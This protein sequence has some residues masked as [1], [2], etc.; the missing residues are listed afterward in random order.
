M[1]AILWRPLALFEGSTAR[2]GMGRGLGDYKG[3]P[4][5]WPAPQYDE[6]E[7]PEVAREV[8]LPELVAAEIALAGPTPFVGERYLN[9]TAPLA[10]FV[11]TIP[12]GVLATME[13]Q[14]FPPLESDE[15]AMALALLLVAEDF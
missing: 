3:T 2:Y 15:G 13:M 5:N 6:I 1:L 9:I 4:Y 8:D 7:Q 12:E 14:G 10:P 11:G